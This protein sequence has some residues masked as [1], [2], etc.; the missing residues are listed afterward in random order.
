MVVPPDNI[1][2]RSE[3]AGAIAVVSMGGENAGAQKA[4]KCSDCLDHGVV[5]G[6]P[7][8]P[9]TATLADQSKTFGSIAPITRP[10]MLPGNN[11]KAN[12]V[13]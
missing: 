9:Q 8:R 12:S 4:E 11:F 13:R 2:R 5:L 1:R 10:V 7:L 3:E 6:L